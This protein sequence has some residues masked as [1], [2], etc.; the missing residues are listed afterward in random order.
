MPNT[1]TT[2]QVSASDPC[3]RDRSSCGSI[4]LRQ[5]RTLA[6]LKWETANHQGHR[7]VCVNTTTPS[8]T[9][10]THDKSQI[11]TARIQRLRISSFPLIFPENP[12]QDSVLSKTSWGPSPLLM[13][14][15]EFAHDSLLDIFLRGTRKFPPSEKRLK[16]SSHE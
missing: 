14:T 6:T 1:G 5:K 4:S 9:T 3:N 12:Q 2:L 10:N 7:G 16:T 15:M 13:S 8:T 11:Q